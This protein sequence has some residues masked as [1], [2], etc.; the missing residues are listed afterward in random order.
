MEF[1]Y[2]ALFGTPVAVERWA[3]KPVCANCANLTEGSKKLDC[4]T[5][6][7]RGGIIPKES[8]DNLSCAGYHNSDF[9]PRK[10]LVGMRMMIDKI[11]ELLG[12]EKEE[13]RIHMKA[14][15]A[16]YEY[17]RVKQGIEIAE[18]IVDLVSKEFAVYIETGRTDWI[19]CSDRMPPVET[20]VYIVAQRK[21]KDGTC[22]YI[23]TTAIYE[24][25]TVSENDSEWRWEDIDGE[26]DEENE[27]YIIPEGWWENRH[28]N[29]DDHYNNAVDDKVIAWMPMPEYNP[30]G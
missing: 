13:Y 12:K 11:R 24:N 18:N 3:V 1:W 6:Q 2:K 20:E 21:F 16:A 10:G 22:R 25:G 27:C 29:P 17:E 23:R 14:R 30:I 26:W 28:Y 15:G 4:Y 7:V 8:A 9:K 5:C 19:M